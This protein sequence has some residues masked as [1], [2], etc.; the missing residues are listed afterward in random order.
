MTMRALAVILA[1]GLLALAGCSTGGERPGGAG[2]SSPTSTPSPTPVLPD[3]QAFD[4]ADNEP[5]RGAKVAAVQFLEGL[6]YGAGQEGAEA[7]RGRVPDS[8]A[9]DGA[10][11]DAG[12]LLG[13]PDG[14]AIEVVYP[15]LGGL[16][17][18]K[19]A[20]FAVVD[21][22]TAGVP[23][24]DERRLTVDVR[25]EKEGGEWRVS[26]VESLGGNPDDYDRVALAAD[27]EVD[28]DV[29]DVLGSDAVELSDTA[30]MDLLDGTVDERVVDLVNESAADYD[31]GLTVFSTGHTY[32]VFDTDRQSNHT[33][34]RAVDIWEIDG[35]PVSYWRDQPLEGNPARELMTRALDSGSD[36]VGGPW[37]FATDSGATFTNEVHQDHLHLG[38]ES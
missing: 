17:S 27:E 25:L 5:G 6:T 29:R 3:V 30:I 23:E 33:R 1:S 38:F 19:A 22:F 11:E 36:E 8:V 20:V 2:T 12:D 37:A 24:A 35:Q 26:G 21:V 9:T 18:S 14:A 16:T 15:Q 7:A 32:N 34:G 4:L 10:F 31:L 13:S 28:A